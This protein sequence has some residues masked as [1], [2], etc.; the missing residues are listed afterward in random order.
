MWKII[1]EVQCLPDENLKSQALES[2]DRR[3]NF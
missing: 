1:P 2:E 3:N